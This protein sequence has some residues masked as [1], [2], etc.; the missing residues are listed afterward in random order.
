MLSRRVTHNV[1]VTVIKRWHGDTLHYYYSKIGTWYCGYI[2][3]YTGL[4]THCGRMTQ[5]CIFTLQLCK[6]D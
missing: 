4:L 6:T 3:E 1:I 5:I 2:Y